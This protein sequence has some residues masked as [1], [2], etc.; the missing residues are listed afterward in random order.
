MSVVAS[1]RPFD[2]NWSYIGTPF[3]VFYNPALI[4]SRD[5]YFL[6]VESKYIDE[7]NYDARGALVVPIAEFEMFGTYG[8]ADA[9][10]TMRCQSSGLSAS[11]GGEYVGES[12]YKISTGV[13]ARHPVVQLGASF[14]I[15]NLDNKFPVLSS[16]IALGIYLHKDYGW[17]SGL[18]GGL[19]APAIMKQFSFIFH[20]FYVSERDST[21][22]FGVSAGVG[23]PLMIGPLT[24]TGFVPYELMFSC[25]FDKAS[26]VRW[27]RTLRFNL[28][29]STLAL[30][31]D[32]GIG[33]VLTIGHSAI[34]TSNGQRNSKYF[35][36]LGIVFLRGYIPSHIVSA[37]GGYAGG[38]EKSGAI[39]YN[40][41][42]LPSTP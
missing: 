8:G 15:A 16:D 41:Y 40:L 13:A 27:E 11:V 6:A 19:F 17:R 18:Y 32:H 10:S 3:A 9:F 33:S 36:N 7:T 34:N 25:Y 26:I 14:D 24:L 38:G 31:A 2:W 22:L 20:N 12:H 42:D 28:D 37:F 1:G 30:I 23:G 29:L 21:N 5:G 35:V 4:N 39:L